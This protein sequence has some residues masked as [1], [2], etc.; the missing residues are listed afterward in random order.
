MPGLPCPSPEAPPYG[1]I[2]PVQAQ[3]TVGDHYVLSC[4]VGYVLL[5]VGEHGIVSPVVIN[6]S[7]VKHVGAFSH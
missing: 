2:A 3:Y 7:G 4:D 6:F 5:E 1:R